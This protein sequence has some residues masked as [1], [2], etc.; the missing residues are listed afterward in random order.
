[1]R[2]LKKPQR[3]VIIGILI[4][5]LLGAGGYLYVQALDQGSDT[6][7]TTTSSPSTASTT[8]SG[9]DVDWASL[10]TTNVTLL[11]TAFAITSAGTYVLTGTTTAG[12]TVNTDG[13]VRIV[14]NTATIKSTDGAAI[15]IQSAK[16]TYI[17]TAK[18]TT[19]T[20]QDSA[21]HSDATIDGAIYSADDLF[22]EG[23]GTLN[24]TSSYADAVVS[25]D[26]LTVISGTYGINSADDGIHG[27]DS[28]TILNGDISITAGGDGIKATNIED[29][30]KGNVTIKGG[31]IT[32]SATNQGIQAE[33]TLEIN[34]GTI[35]VT[36]ISEGFEAA[37][38]TINDGK[39]TI[40]ASD[41]GINGSASALVSNPTVTFNGGEVNVTVGSGDTDAVDSNGDVTLNGG[42]ISLT[43][44]TSSIDYD[45][46]AAFNGGTLIVNG[47]QLT[48]IPAGM[49]GG[50]GGGMR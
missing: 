35:T 36:Q 50:Q 6:A 41:D 40:T 7:A 16:N 42:T 28:V 10:P 24:V 39:I 1:M 22:L 5:I 17:Q 34:G 14:L 46:S 27:K 29:A 25:K 23:E 31:T 45:G 47:T 15:Y 18:D 8:S 30:T 49:M 37:T 44:P 26:D 38:I 2:K 43:A 32:I 21:N 12:V 20:V 11:N 4:A 3:L 33:Q 13:N 48:A 9:D 19:N